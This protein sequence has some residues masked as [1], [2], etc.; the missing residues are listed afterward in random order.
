MQKLIHNNSLYDKYNKQIENL[1]IKVK[2]N[3]K[4]LRRTNSAPSK[5][6]TSLRKKNVIQ[7]TQ[8]SFYPRK[9]TLGKTTH[10]RFSTILPPISSRDALLIL[11]RQDSSSFKIK[12][13]EWK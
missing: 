3:N 11:R 7:R 2:E 8:E 5:M 6:Q 10:S 12:P 4:L 9:Q 13:P 1:N